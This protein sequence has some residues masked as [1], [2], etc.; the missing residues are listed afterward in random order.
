M[1]DTIPLPAKM[2][3]MLVSPEEKGERRGHHPAGVGISHPVPG[4]IATNT[5]VDA[6][7]SARVRAVSARAWPMRASTCHAS[8]EEAA[9]IEKVLLRSKGPMLSPRKPIPLADL[10]LTRSNPI[11]CLKK[12]HRARCITRCPS[13]RAIGEEDTAVARFDIA[14]AR[15]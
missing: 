14:A 8:L 10:G 6:H 15:F 9:K 4:H 5:G 12:N 2:G 13:I 1:S 3:I 7:S 11:V